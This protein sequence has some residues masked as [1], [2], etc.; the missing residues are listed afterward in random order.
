[1]G[2]EFGKL[3]TCV[4]VTESFFCIPETNTLLINSTS[5]P[6]KEC[7]THFQKAVFK[8]SVDLE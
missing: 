6:N 2:K 8:K 3:D 5:E 4:Y 1:M 7:S